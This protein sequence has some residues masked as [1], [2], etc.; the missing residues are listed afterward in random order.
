MAN[1]LLHEYDTT[2][3]KD[4]KIE[5]RNAV[6]EVKYRV[7]VYADGCA[8]IIP[9]AIIEENEHILKSL[10]DSVPKK[11][12]TSLNKGGEYELDMDLV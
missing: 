4:K 12:D 9:F 7:R 3:G 10:L 8:E 5:I 1:D 11:H 2:V 6:P